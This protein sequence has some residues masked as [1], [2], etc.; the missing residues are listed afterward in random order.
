MV[1]MMIV[2]ARWVTCPR[3][4]GYALHSVKF[5][6]LFHVCLQRLVPS[7]L[8]GTVI[9]V[10]K[11]NGRKGLWVTPSKWKGKGWPVE[12]P[13]QAHPYINDILHFLKETQT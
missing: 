11:M 7:P 3:H 4:Q 12:L 9:V 6:L 13:F 8:C 2:L 5:L 1:P 10:V